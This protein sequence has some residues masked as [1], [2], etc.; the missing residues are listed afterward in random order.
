MGNPV[1]EEGYAAMSEVRQAPG[2]P[3]NPADFPEK[4]H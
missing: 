2:F 3:K 1:K 4:S